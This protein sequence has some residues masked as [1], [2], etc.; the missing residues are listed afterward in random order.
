MS[1]SPAAERTASVI[2]CA[3][4]SPSECPAQPSTPGHSSPAS[5]QARP[6]STGWTSVPMPTRG[7]SVMP[8]HLQFGQ[9]EVVRHGDLG[10]A[11]VA[12]DGGDRDAGGAHDRGVVGEL[13]AV[14]R[15]PA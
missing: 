8:S 15:A 12:G 10:G 3:T 6:G 4:M 5:R 9:R 14:R 11:L 1:P 13:G 7:S 2:A